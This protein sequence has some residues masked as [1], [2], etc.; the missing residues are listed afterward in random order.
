MQLQAKSRMCP[1]RVPL[2]QKGRA[3]GKGGI[4]APR[5]PL[6]A[7]PCCVPRLWPGAGGGVL[8]AEELGFTC[9]DRPL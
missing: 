6:P 3:D 2:G 7:A 4:A 1:L 9:W 5:C 8:A